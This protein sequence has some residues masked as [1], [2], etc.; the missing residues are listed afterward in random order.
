MIYLNR[1]DLNSQEGMERAFR[2]YFEDV[3]TECDG[4]FNAMLGAELESCDYAGKRVTL[5]VELK[6][7][8]ANPGGILHGGVS[9]SLMDYTMGLL[10]RYFG[11][12]VMT[13][14]VSMEVSYLR[15]GT[16]GGQ[17]LI[18]ADMTMGGFTFCHATGAAWMDGAE[19]EPVCTSTGVYYVSR[20]SGG[21][22]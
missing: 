1:D 12:G 6:S 9:A 21:V 11:G 7:W 16:I 17:M 14:T 2:G 20:K 18:R 4:T 13:P 8:M 10:C 3:K 15:P 22:K 5:R 19:D